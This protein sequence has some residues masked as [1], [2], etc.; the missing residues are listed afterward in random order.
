MDLIRASSRG[1]LKLVK[2]LCDQVVNV[3]EQ[4]EGGW[5]ALM[6]AGHL[7]VVKELCD[8][9]G[10]NLEIAAYNGKTALSW[11]VTWD[12]ILVKELCK[13]G[14][15][16]LFREARSFEMRTLLTK[17]QF[18]RNILVLVDFIQIELLRKVHEWI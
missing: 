10:A 9:G 6:V 4:N 5:T 15:K 16:P 8:R 11:N 12:D 1:N 17:Q 2:K 13:R 18:R 14:A 7:G 3:D